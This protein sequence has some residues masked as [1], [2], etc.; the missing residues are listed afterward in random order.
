MK[1]TLQERVLDAIYSDGAETE[2]GDVFDKY[3]TILIVLN[4]FAIVLES[5]PQLEKPYHL[6][7]QLFEYF[8]V[9]VFSTEYILRIWTAPLL[10]PD[11]SPIRSRIKFVTSALGIIDLLA[12]LP[13]YIPFII[14]IDL[15][16]IR[17]LRLLRL[18]RVMKLSRHSE[19]LRTIRRVL[20]NSKSELGVTVFVVFILL[21]VSS[22]LMYYIEHEAQPEAFQNIG[23]GFWWAVATLTTVGYGD[24]YPVTG[25][26]KFISGLIALLGIGLVALPT[27]IISSAF[28]TEIENKNKK[29]KHCAFDH[30]TMTTRYCPHCGEKL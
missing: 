25:L 23:Q 1:K 14:T 10:Y 21:I 3:I 8:S 28:M 9:A 15:R 17:V 13:F 22:S 29:K 27:G 7:F 6:Y 18:L 24:I 26:G 12:V 30:T 4:V 5:Y 16:F 19:A 20:K 11:L 2:R